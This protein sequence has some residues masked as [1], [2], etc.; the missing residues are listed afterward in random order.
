MLQLPVL[1]HWATL[2][3][4][5]TEAAEAELAVTRPATGRVTTAPPMSAIR[6]RLRLVTVLVVAVVVSL[7]KVM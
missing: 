3:Q 6:T 4:V 2:S 1:S 7:R 5:E